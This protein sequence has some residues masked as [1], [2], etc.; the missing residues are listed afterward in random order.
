MA[1]EE[2]ISQSAVSQNLAN[3][4]AY[5]IG[6]AERERARISGELMRLYT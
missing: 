5:A 2:G 3:N 6:L 4:G 1:A